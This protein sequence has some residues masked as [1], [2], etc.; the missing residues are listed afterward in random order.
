VGP[1]GVHVVDVLGEIVQRVAAGRGSAHAQLERVG[2]QLG[3]R[4]LDLHPAMLRFREAK[5]VLDWRR[6]MGR[7][8]PDDED[9]ER[10][11]E[12]PMPRHAPSHDA[13]VVNLA[14]ACSTNAVSGSA[15]RISMS[16]STTVFG[17]PV[18]R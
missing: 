6:G 12:K 5:A 7:N 13:G 14:S 16:S 8:A 2:W 18:T 11:E 17:T 15:P 9:G 3:E 4:G 1:K 10:R